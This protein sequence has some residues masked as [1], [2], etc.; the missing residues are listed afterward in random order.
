MIAALEQL[1]PQNHAR[2]GVLRLDWQLLAQHYGQITDLPLVH[3]LVSSP[4]QIAGQPEA[5]TTQA[6]SSILSAIRAATAEQRQH[7]LEHYLTERVSSVLRLPMERMDIQQPLTALGLDSLMAIELKNSLEHELEIRIPIV[8]F[9]QGPSITQF[10]SQLRNQL[11]ETIL[12]APLTDTPAA[13]TDAERQQPQSDQIPNQDINKLLNQLNVEELQA[14]INEQGIEISQN[15][16]SQEAEKLLTQLDQL[17][18]QQVDSLLKQIAQKE[19]F[20]R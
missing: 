6:E 3:H 19:D 10:A 5:A 17:S 14:Q 2:I 20:N 4:A 12:E 13:Q 15:L 9:L 16:S 11:A 18:D 8:T 1:T 7:I